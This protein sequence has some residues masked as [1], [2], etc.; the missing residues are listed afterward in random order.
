MDMPL[1]NTELLKPAAMI[2]LLGAE[3][4]NGLYE[5]TGL[6]T[7]LALKGVYIHLYNKTHTKPKR[8]MGHIT[9]LGDSIDEIR[10]KAAIVK[11]HLGMKQL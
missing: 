4:V 2:N 1:G 11:N 10:E 6:D 3:G 8:K 5:I 7:I 9:I